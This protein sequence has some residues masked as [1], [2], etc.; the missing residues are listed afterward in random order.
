IRDVLPSTGSTDL[1]ANEFYL[2][3]RRYLQRFDNVDNVRTALQLFH[4]ALEED[5]DF[6]LAV[7]GLTAAHWRMYPATKDVVVADSALIYG[8]QVESAPSVPDEVYV[9][10]GLVYLGT[11]RTQQ[12]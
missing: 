2:H 8:R 7:A 5:P 10:L 3:A 12:S 9:S 4:R 1:G 6:I 11:D